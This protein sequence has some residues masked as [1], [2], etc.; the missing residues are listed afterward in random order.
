M[1]DSQLSFYLV[2]Y[3][4]SILGGTSNFSKVVMAANAK[5]ACRDVRFWAK[6]ELGRRA[7]KLKAVLWK[8]QD[9]GQE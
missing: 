7:V 8:E 2:T 1:S 4:V 9:D 3:E 5:E 6:H